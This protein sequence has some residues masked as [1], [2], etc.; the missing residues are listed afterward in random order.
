[1]VNKG[2]QVQQGAF[3]LDLL[4]GRKEE[5]QAPGRKQIL[6]SHNQQD[7]ETSTDMQLI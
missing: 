1:V 6:L 5:D 7:R 3:M 4:C 2:S